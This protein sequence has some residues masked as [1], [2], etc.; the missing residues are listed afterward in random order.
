MSTPPTD[1]ADGLLDSGTAADVRSEAIEE[2]QEIEVVPDAATRVFGD[3]LDLAVQYAELLA[4]AGVERGLIGPRETGRLWSRHLLNSAVLAEAVPTAAELPGPSGRVPEVVDVGSGAGLP[5]VPLALARPDLRVTLLEPMERRCR[6][7]SEVV[8]QLGLEE[9]IEVVRGRAPDLA[10]RP[11]HRD[12]DVSVARAVAPLGRLGAVLLPM[13]R[14][15]GVMLA[16]RGSRILE[17][18]QAARSDLD[19][20]GWREV[21]V[22][23]CGADLVEEPTRVLR[24]T[25]TVAAARGDGGR[26]RRGTDD[27]QA[28]RATQPRRVR[29]G[30]PDRPARGR[31]RST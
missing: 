27:R 12:F 10:Q 9:Q 14:S 13:T 20:Q 29:E 6:F 26:G 15:G 22:V 7:L 5:G 24:A 1:S 4:T 23:T 11:P 3:R 19:S 21:D 17:E 31:S 18:L 25:R 16:L 8:A 2:S 30:T 28:R